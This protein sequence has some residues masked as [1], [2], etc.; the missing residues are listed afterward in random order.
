MSRTPI[1]RLLPWAGA[2]GQPCYVATDG[3]VGGYV[4]HLADRMEELQLDTGAELL[5]HVADLLDARPPS[6]SC[7][8]VSAG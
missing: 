2:D 4:S 1:M 5:D 6:M 8:S 3:H 7:G